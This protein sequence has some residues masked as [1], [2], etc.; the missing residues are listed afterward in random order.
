MKT[1]GGFVVGIVVPFAAIN[2]ETCL[3]RRISFN[4]HWDS[5]II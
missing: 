3:G 5:T 1:F 2:V 4:S